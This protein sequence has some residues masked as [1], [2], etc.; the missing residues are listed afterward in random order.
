MKKNILFLF[1]FYSFLG[2]YAQSYTS[3]FTGD[4]TNVET[5][6]EG[7]LCMM[8]GA[9]EN[10]SAMIWFLKQSGGGDIVV[11]RATGSNG[12]NDYLYSGLGFPVNS[13]ETLVI[14]S[15]AAAND[16]Y[17]I[18]QIHNAEALWIA[19]GDQNNYVTFWKNTPI[20]TEINYLINKGVVIGG[21]SAGMAILG[22]A[23]FSAANGTTTT[24]TALNNPFD[25]TVAI[26]YD[27]F[28][29]HPLMNHV[30]TD[31]HYDNPDRRGRHA[32]FLARLVTEHNDRFFG[33]AAEE[34]VAV[35]IDRFGIASVFGEYP[36]QQDFA[37]F[38]VT[39]CQFPIAPENCTVGT[40]LTWNRNQEAIKVYKINATPNGNNT[41]DLND[42]K[43]TN[44]GGAWE[45]WFVVNGVPSFVQGAFP[46]ECTPIAIEN[47]SVYANVSLFPNPTNQKITL[48][49]PEY[50]S[51]VSVVIYSLEGKKVLTTNLNQVQT[52][53]S[54]EVLP[55]GFYFVYLDGGKSVLSF[56]KE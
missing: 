36:A 12:Y 4:T 2:A 32:A 56:C 8:G 41:F 34:Y 35:C 45:N 25:N 28:I 9:T 30:I 13:V 16:Q 37:Y 33:I 22:Q 11:I 23:Y 10:D 18:R 24:A 6:V 29:A 53:I 51:P 44:G 15:L 39:N 19:G 1:L 48:S 21:T 31:T 46:P 52:E 38:L 50:E 27:D 55:K 40:P 49:F 47:G 54:T 5:L 3:Y 42:W 26:G 20:E 43:T 17:V 14:P 7:G